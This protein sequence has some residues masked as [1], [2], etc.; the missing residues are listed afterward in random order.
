M[1]ASNKNPS[2]SEMYQNIGTF[3][4]CHVF[5]NLGILTRNTA[6]IE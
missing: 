5:F 4:D 3:Y 6:N 1:I 2:R